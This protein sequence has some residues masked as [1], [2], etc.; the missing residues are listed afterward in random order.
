MP[1]TKQ[2]K[3]L[4]EKQQRF[5][6]SHIDDTRDAIRNRVI[7]LLSV[8]AGLRAKEIASVEWPMVIDVEGDLTD[9]IRLE[10]KSAKGSSGGFVYMSERLKSAPS[11]LLAVSKPVGTIIKAKSG[12]PFSAAFMT[13]WFWRLYREL[14][15]EGCS[16]HS[17]R[18]TAITKRARTISQHDGSLRD[19]QALARYSSLQL[20]Q[21]Y[22]EVSE[23]ANTL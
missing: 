1:L 9:A 15:F 5:M 14:G 7:F 21:R 12:K 8:D 2:A 13:N 10:N 20:T 18:R 22:L 17:G 6:L 3:P 23:L 11:D 4:N 16:P 19:V